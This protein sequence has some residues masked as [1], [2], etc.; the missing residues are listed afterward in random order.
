MDD[1][2]INHF[3]TGSIHFITMNSAMVNDHYPY[4]L[5]LFVWEYT[6][7]SDKPL[8]MMG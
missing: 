2:S 6:L 4:F 1:T 8:W 3:I 5:W 7:F